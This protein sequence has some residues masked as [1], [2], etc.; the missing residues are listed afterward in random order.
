MNSLKILIYLAYIKYL[1]FDSIEF[2]SKEVVDFSNEKGLDLTIRID[3]K[4]ELSE[5]ITE[6]KELGVN[7]S[8]NDFLNLLN[9]VN[10]KNIISMNLNPEIKSSKNLFEESINELTEQDDFICGDEILKL[11]KDITDTFGVQDSKQSSLSIENIIDQ[12]NEILL[13]EI[14]EFFETHKV[15]RSKSRKAGNVLQ[16]LKNFLDWDTIGEDIFYSKKD[17]T[18]FKIGEILKNMIYN[19]TCVF[20]SIY[21]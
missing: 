20:P 10:R 13:D 1:K 11:L 3:K 2:A 21:S 4:K 15:E 12:K 14:I 19:L 16:F 5:Q 17:A 18:G 7:L 9:V 6:L 8:L